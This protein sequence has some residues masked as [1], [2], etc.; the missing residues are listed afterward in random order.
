M[1]ENDYIYSSL[2]RPYF[3]NLILPIETIERY[4]NYYLENIKTLYNAGVQFWFSDVQNIEMFYTE[5]M[6]MTL[7]NSNEVTVD[8]W[9]YKQDVEEFGRLIEREGTFFP[10]T[11]RLKDNII[12]CIEGKHRVYS[13]KKINSNKK[14]L[15]F[16]DHS[17]IEDNIVDS[18][19]NK[20][21]ELYTL[22]NQ[23]C[24]YKLLN[25]NLN[26]L[27]I[28]K[29]ENNVYKIGYRERDVIQALRSIR[30]FGA[31]L[32]RLIYR[33]RDIIKPSPI[34]NS[35]EEFYKFVNS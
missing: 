30:F 32:G 2:D 24:S 8:N 4:M 18:I 7:F 23:N 14:M 15:C 20:P 13:L 6:I 16:L 29:I 9:L 27:S 10:V 26:F 34:I 25:G 33:Y 28:C 31:F 3:D 21:I 11:V 12:Q 17:L 22:I 35:E 1:N 19:L 5:E